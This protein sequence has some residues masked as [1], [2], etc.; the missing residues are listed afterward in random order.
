MP[1]DF[2]TITIV[3]LDSFVVF[4]LPLYIN[5]NIMYE[6]KYYHIISLY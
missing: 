1:Y 6:K 5:L 4:K 3:L 2:D